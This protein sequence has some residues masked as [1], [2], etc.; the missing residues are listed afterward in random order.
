[1]TAK[2]QSASIPGFWEGVTRESGLISGG[3]TS[4]RLETPRLIL[5]PPTLDDAPAVQT[6]ASDP[7]VALV[8][9]SIQHPYPSGAA[10]E[11][12]HSI[13][14]ET[15]PYRVRLAITR[16]EESD[17]LIGVVGCHP[18]E[19]GVAELTYM[20]SPAWWN[21]GIA[22][23]AA[24]RI[25][26][27]AFNEAPFEAVTA[28]AMVTNPASERVLA[29]TGFHREREVARE[30]PVR[31]GTFL[32]S[33]WRVE[34]SGW[35]PPPRNDARPGYS[36][37]DRKTEALRGSPSRKSIRSSTSAAGVGARMRP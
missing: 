11:F 29:K 24:R 6:I 4:I 21:R 10:E 37:Y 14:A 17:V 27:Y 20:V 30:L 12:I 31:G 1:M 36:R 35:K 23:E 3:D 25:V 9:A 33:Y 28:R 13:L 5:R 22:T 15:E 2:V 18:R 32:I 7:R 8:T 19:A 26:S 16:R 34:R